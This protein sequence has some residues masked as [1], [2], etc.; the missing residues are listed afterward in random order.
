MEFH[1]INHFLLDHFLL[2]RA[3]TVHQPKNNGATHLYYTLLHS[4]T[5]Q[6]EFPS[7]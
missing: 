5:P 7:A 1:P 6:R 4:T 3:A 2:D